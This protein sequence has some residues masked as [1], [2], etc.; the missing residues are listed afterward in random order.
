MEQEFRATASDL[1]VDLNQYNDP[2]YR[3]KQIENKQFVSLEPLR[4]NIKI[5]TQCF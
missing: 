2:D 3:Q 4:Y 5:R 1:H